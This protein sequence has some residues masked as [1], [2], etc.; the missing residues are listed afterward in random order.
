[1]GDP[2][3]I[4]NHM[5]ATDHAMVNIQGQNNGIAFASG[6]VS[7]QVFSQTITIMWHFSDWGSTRSGTNVFSLERCFII[8]LE[9]LKSRQLRNEIVT[10]ADPPHCFLSCNLSPNQRGRDN[11]HMKINISSVW[12]LITPADRKPAGKW[13]WACPDVVFILTLKGHTQ[14]Q[15][16]PQFPEKI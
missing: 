1:M 6:C 5:D 4:N 8:Q 16:F 12:K 10:P 3:L 7:S 15:S 14:T 9:F 13:A 2:P 11:E